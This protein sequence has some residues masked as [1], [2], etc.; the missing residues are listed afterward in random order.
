LEWALVGSGETPEFVTAPD[1]VATI[2]LLLD[3][4]AP[5]DELTFGDGGPKQPSTPVIE[6]L[7]SRGLTGNPQ[8]S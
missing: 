1:W 6:L 2:A 8:T 3:G 4:G 7:R 5:T